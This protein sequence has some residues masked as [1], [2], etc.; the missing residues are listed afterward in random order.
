MPAGITYEVT[1]RF[2]I[3]GRELVNTERSI[4]RPTVIRRAR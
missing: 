2:S 1:Q 4:V 3:A